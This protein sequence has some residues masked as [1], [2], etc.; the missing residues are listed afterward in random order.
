[1]PSPRTPSTMWLNAS[2]V[3]ATNSTFDTPPSAIVSLGPEWNHL[4]RRGSPSPGRLFSGQV[5]AA[6][7]FIRIADAKVP[8]LGN[9]PLVP[10]ERR[11]RAVFGVLS[12]DPQDDSHAFRN[13][14]VRTPSPTGKMPDPRN[15]DHYGFP[16]RS[17]RRPRHRPARQ[18]PV[19]ACRRPAAPASNHALASSSRSIRRSGCST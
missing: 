5:C 1:M 13:A 11:L 18:P 12:G 16:V 6:S 19:P 4:A 17:P 8:L 10:G 3:T 15:G 9:R 2:C 7:T 14:S